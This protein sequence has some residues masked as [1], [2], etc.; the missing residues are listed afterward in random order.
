MDIEYIRRF[1]AVGHCLNFSKAAEMLFISQPTLSHSIANLEKKL[2]TP[3]LVRSTKSVKLTHAGELFLP[4][5]IEIVNLYESAV[6]KIAQELHLGCDALNIGYVGPSMDN[7]ITSWIS[8]F[9]TVSPDVKVHLMHYNSSKIAEAFENRAIH[10]GILYRMHAE[11]VPSLNYQEVS[12]ETFK[13]LVHAGH[14]LANQSC[15][16][17]ASLKNEPFLICDRSS[18]PS[19]YD[20]VLSICEKRGLRPNISQ[21]VTLVGDIYRLVSAGLG[22]AVLSYSETRSFDAYNVKF[23]DIDG[24]GEDLINSVVLAWLDKP[25]T[26]VRQFKEI[27]SKTLSVYSHHS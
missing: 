8:A 15:V 22:V 7:T 23:V 24:D 20:R 18:S 26:L 6:N 9:R 2:G 13:L 10:L 14:P 16:K 3:L 11:T 17:L 4:A 12:K 27:A 21:Y 1:I 19:Y 25:S 5:A